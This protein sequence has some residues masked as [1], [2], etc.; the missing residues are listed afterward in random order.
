MSCTRRWLRPSPTPSNALVHLVGQAEERLP[1]VEAAAKY[2]TSPVRSAANDASRLP[3]CRH[4]RPAGHSRV[5]R[6]CQ[7][8]VFGSLGPSVEWRRRPHP[9]PMF[10]SETVVVVTDEDGVT[11]G[12]I[13]VAG[14]GVTMGVT[15]AGVGVGLNSRSTTVIS[16]M[17]GAGEPATSMRRTSLTLVPA[18]TAKA[19]K[20]ASSL[21]V[22]M[23]LHARPE[24]TW[25]LP[26]AVPTTMT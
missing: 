23:V 9:S 16:R 19:W 4:E 15:V 25:T 18:G 17:T 26:Q 24:R 13:V 2:G 3:P 11:V 1:G 8:P 5:V 20:G 6:T 10:A 7:A 22:P 14:V 12:L 21:I